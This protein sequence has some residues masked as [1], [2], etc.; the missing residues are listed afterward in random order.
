MMR[1]LFLSGMGLCAA[2]FVFQA[3]N[4]PVFY[5]I[6]QEVKPIEPRIKGSPT[7][8]VV[9]NNTMFVA[10]GKSLHWYKNTDDEQFG[11]DNEKNNVPQ[12]GGRITCLAAT[13]G[14]LYALCYDDADSPSSAVVR[15]YSGSVNWEKLGGSTGLNI[16]D[17]DSLQSIYAAGEVL[18]ISAEKSNNFDILYLD[19]AGGSANSIKKLAYLDG[20]GETPEYAGELCGAVYDGAYYLCTKGQG[21]YKT[22]DPSGGAIRLESSSDIDYSGI[23]YTGIIN[24]GN[25]IAAITREGK[26]YTVQDSVAETNV[27]M[28]SLATGA[29]AIWKQDASANPR[30]LLLSGRQGS[31]EYTT[32]SGYTYG[33]LELEL[34]LD[35]GGLKNGENFREPGKDPSSITDGDND[36]YKSTIGKQPIKH[37]FQAPFEIDNKRTLFAST[38]KNGVW[39]YKERDGTPQ[40]NAE[41]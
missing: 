22:N 20:S 16:G 37:I 13:D 9:F 34:E 24:L 21:I 10:S 4:D 41:E 17:Y 23:D 25:T 5:T 38:Q 33:Y 26:L 11:W 8:F 7:N 1:K 30:K 12:P 3:C 36:R 19:E 35:S 32:S 31:L 27:A 29:L 14:Y 39:S 6:S 40:W 28:G 18:F 2:L 15:R